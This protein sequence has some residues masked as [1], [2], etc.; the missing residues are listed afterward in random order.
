MISYLLPSKYFGNGILHV[1]DLLRQIA[2][3]EF[4]DLCETKV[5]EF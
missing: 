5:S 3:L 4:S 1:S 2:D